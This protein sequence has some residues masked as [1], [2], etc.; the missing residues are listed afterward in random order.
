MNLRSLVGLGWICLHALAFAQADDALDRLTEKRLAA[1]RA[2]VAELAKSRQSL[3][4]PGPFRDYRANLHVHSLLSH[5]SRITQDE[6][7][8]AARQAGTDILMF[9]E[10]PAEH[11]DYFTDGHSGLRDGILMIPE[12]RPKACWSIPNKASKGSMVARL[13]RSPTWFEAAAV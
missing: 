13:K 12:P 11:Y 6:V 7:I 8:V 9:T 2:A 1:V 3:E 4:R 10:H 5:D